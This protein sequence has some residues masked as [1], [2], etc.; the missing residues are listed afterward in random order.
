[1][2]VPRTANSYTFPRGFFPRFLA[3]C[4]QDDQP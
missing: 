4:Q 3:G 2:I 1:V